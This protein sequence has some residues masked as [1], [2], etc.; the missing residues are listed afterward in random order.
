MTID[1]PD[2]L[3][4]LRQLVDAITPLKPA[5]FPLPWQSGWTTWSA[6]RGYGLPRPGR[7]WWQRPWRWRECTSSECGSIR[8]LVDV[9]RKLTGIIIQGDGRLALRPPVQ[10]Q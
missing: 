2:E 4:N 1:L 10:R 9:F 7:S 6:A 5:L 3:Y 8:R